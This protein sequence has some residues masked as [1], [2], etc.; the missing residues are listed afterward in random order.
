MKSAE[1]REKT[2]EELRE[3]AAD[4]AEQIRV[5]RMGLRTSTTKQS[6]EATAA[7]KTRARVLTILQERR[8]ITHS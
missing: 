6:H 1:I 8:K 4:L 7:S 3:M 2:I 5:V